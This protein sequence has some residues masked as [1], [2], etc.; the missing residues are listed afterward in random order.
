MS[1]TTRR[2]RELKHIKERFSQIALI[3]V[4]C[5]ILSVLNFIM[6]M[7]NDAIITFV[8]F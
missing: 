8:V 6:I 1:G 2:R 4:V 3:A 5:T 7:Y